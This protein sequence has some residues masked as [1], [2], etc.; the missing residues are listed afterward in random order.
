MLYNADSHDKDVVNLI[1]LQM[2]LIEIEII[3]N[4]EWLKQVFHNVEV[5]RV[6]EHCFLF[7][8]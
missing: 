7:Y 1:I 5:Y 8:W 2:R 6:S 4:P 3:M